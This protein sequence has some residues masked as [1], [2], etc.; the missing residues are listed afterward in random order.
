MRKFRSRQPFHETVVRSA[1]NR[2]STKKAPHPDGYGAIIC[3]ADLHRLHFS[4]NLF[5]SLS[6]ALLHPA[7]KLI[8]LAIDEGEIVIRE[9]AVLLLQLAFYFVPAAFEFH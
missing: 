1:E 8:F 2:N 4:A 5:L 9:F 3:V 7:E 6:K